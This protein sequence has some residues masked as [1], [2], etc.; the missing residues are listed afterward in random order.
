MCPI[1]EGEDSVRLLNFQHNLITKIENLSQLKRLIFLDFYDNQ[2]ECISGLSSLNSLRVLMLGKNRISKIEKLDA[3]RKLDVLDLHGNKISDINNLNHLSELRVLNLAGNDIVHVNNLDG[4]RSLAELNLRRN[5]IITVS[6]INL[7]PNLQ[8]LFLSFNCIQSF[9]DIS[10]LSQSVALS[11]LSLDGN[12]F[13]LE[14]SYK[15]II[16]KNIP[17]LRQL[18]MKRIS[19]EDKRVANVI[20]KKED[21]KKREH[22]RIT[23]L[24]E[25][26]RIA[27]NNAQRQWEEHQIKYAAT[28]ESGS[29]EV[30]STEAVSTKAPETLFGQERSSDLIICHLAELESDTLFLYGPG[31]LD[32]LDRNW[33]QQAVNTITSVSFKFIDY[34]DI[35]PY[36]G[37]LQAKFPVVQK[38]VFS[39][40]NINSLQQIN[41]LSAIKHLE[42]L[43]IKDGNPVTS[44]TLWKPYILYRLAHLSLRQLNDVEVTAEDI[45]KAEKLFG[46]LSHTTTSHLPQSRLLSLLGDHSSRTR[47]TVDF[48]KMRRGEG[49]RERSLS[50]EGL[51]RAGLQYCTREMLENR[52]E[53][54]KIK[55][56]FSE[57]YVKG[58]LQS[59]ILNHR[60]SKR[61][62]T[63]WPRI[64]AEM[65][66]GYVRDMTNFDNFIENSLENV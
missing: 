17:N 56:S 42:G 25:K 1:L 46:A 19:E 43:T 16:L 33:G 10:C 36:L 35:V 62:E 47:Q 64:L 51:G 5:K 32:A 65:V 26:R 15:H 60:K 6:E 45:V 23:H 11:E 54:W 30:V 27:I 40:T 21:E 58:L 9:V 44:F 66:Q 57:N 3:L 28:D 55:K 48:E 24:K 52:K 22:G 61:L 29:N 37:K 7:L 14:V 59:C 34:D 41:A 18:D 38:L 12:P 13:A 49:R 2:L 50:N 20:A 39:S 63:L 53:E 31:S 8:R 4:M